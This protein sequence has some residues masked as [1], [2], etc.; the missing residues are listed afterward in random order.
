MSDGQSAPVNFAAAFTLLLRR[1]EETGNGP[2]SLRGVARR[3]AELKHET[4]PTHQQI[5]TERR[6]IRRYMAE[7]LTPQRKTLERIAAALNASVDDFP[8]RETRAELL[9]RL[10]AQHEDT[11][12]LRRELDSGGATRRERK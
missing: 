12:A 9:R 4:V 1:N 2:S 10:R 6:L 11:E 5:E 3:M 7:E 8:R